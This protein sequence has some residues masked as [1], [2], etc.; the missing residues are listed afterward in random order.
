MRESYTPI[1]REKLSALVE[2]YV[3]GT[4]GVSERILRERSSTERVIEDWIEEHEL[5][6][7]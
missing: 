6:R 3:G 5:V 2:G 1:V 7:E 4:V